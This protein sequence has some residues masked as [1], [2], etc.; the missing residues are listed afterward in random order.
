MNLGQS[1]R[2]SPTKRS[3][4]ENKNPKVVLVSVKGEYLRVGLRSSFV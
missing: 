4:N 1:I 3:K 2:R